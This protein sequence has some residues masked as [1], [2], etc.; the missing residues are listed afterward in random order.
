MFAEEDC[1]RAQAELE[2]DFSRAKA[3][4]YDI[5]VWAEEQNKSTLTKTRKIQLLEKIARVKGQTRY[6][7][8]NVYRQYKLT[9]KGTELADKLAG[10]P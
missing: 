7:H 2:A 1:K 10:E 9:Q 3:Q 5:L 4:K 8:R 6:T